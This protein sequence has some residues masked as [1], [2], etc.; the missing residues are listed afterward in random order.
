[1]GARACPLDSRTS[2]HRNHNVA[3][4]SR[5][6]SR[7]LRIAWAVAPAP[8]IGQWSPSE[9]GRRTHATVRASWLTPPDGGTCLDGPCRP[10]RDS[11]R[12]PGLVEHATGRNAMPHIDAHSHTHT[13][14]GLKTSVGTK[15]FLDTTRVPPNGVARIEPWAIISP[16]SCDAGVSVETCPEN[17]LPTGFRAVAQVHS[18]V[19]TKKSAFP[20]KP[21]RGRDSISSRS[22]QDR[23]GHRCRRAAF[24]A[25]G[26]AGTGPARCIF[27]RGRH[28]RR[29]PR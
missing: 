6:R 4:S 24:D 14:L 9:A 23:R 11:H 21:Y 3:A 26:G 25:A 29:E 1:M 5:R 7:R 13:A 8:G 16:A 22:R 28:H 15:R 10:T 12:T 20:L 2:R 27:S 19:L 18:D 17:Q